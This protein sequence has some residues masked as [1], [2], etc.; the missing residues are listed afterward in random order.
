MVPYPPGHGQDDRLDSIDIGA[1]Q[2]VGH[3]FGTSTAHIKGVGLG[4]ESWGSPVAVT[5]VPGSERASWYL[6][7]DAA[8][9]AMP[10]RL[11]GEVAA[12]NGRRYIREVDTNG[13]VQMEWTPRVGNTAGAALIVATPPAASGPDDDSQYALK[14]HDHPGTVTIGPSQ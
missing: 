14:G 2:N 12:T 8:G 11:I 13:V 5:L 3:Y 7:V 10:A 9:V 4:A 1:D 6:P